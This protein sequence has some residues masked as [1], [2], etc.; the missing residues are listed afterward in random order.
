VI[1]GRPR[2]LLLIPHLGGG[3]AER[4]FTLLARG[5]SPQK[6]DVH[7]GLITGSEFGSD[8]L[9]PSV[10]VHSFGRRRVRWA[11]GPLLRLV[12]QLQPDVVLSGMA[13]LN[14]LVLLLKPL[15]PARTRV[16][17]RQN[18]TVSAD[19]RSGQLRAYT[20]WLYR[21]LYRRADRIV[22]QTEAMAA[23]LSSQ[24]GLEDSHLVVLPN[25]VDADTIQVSCLEGPQR[26][27]GPGPHLLAIGR[28]AREKGFDL[29]LEAFSSFRVKFPEADLI[30]LGSGPEESA[31]MTM[32]QSMCLGTAVRFAGHVFHPESYFA[33]ATL[34][35]LP[36]R[37]EGLPNA[38]LEAAAGG[39]PIAALPSSE[40]LVELLK[41]KPGA[42][43]APEISSKALTRSLLAAMQNIRPGKRFAHP[44]IEPFRMDRAIAGYEALIDQTLHG[45]LQCNT[46]HLSSRR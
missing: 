8:S 23:D 41:G 2:V 21:H 5:F 3:G 20:R 26:W 12:Q 40:G 19:L 29:L 44:W 28:L 32:R 25:P 43:V 18:S 27:S 30:I 14:F 4:V 13:H 35:V 11:A 36:S 31:L 9:P 16:L 15:F 39:L 17:V 7:L 33:G 22:C 46:S 37:Q 10:T 24:A 1:T 38:L 42:W 34:F 45:H 6:Y